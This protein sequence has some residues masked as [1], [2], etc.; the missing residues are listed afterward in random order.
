MKMKYIIR[1]KDTLRSVLNQGP[2]ISNDSLPP[3]CYLCA[4]GATGISF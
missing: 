3:G 4:D 1:D 2:D